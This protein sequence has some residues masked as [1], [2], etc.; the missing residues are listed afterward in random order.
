MAA[1][2]ALTTG[3]GLAG[4]GAASVAEAYPGP[5]P[6]YDWCAGQFWDPG[7]GNN[8][9]GGRCH[10]DFYGDGDP[11]DR[12][13]WNGPGDWRADGGRGWDRDHPG[14]PGGPGGRGWGGPGG[15][16]WGGPGDHGR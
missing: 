8:W 10:D 9:D 15:G 14:G 1:A 12:D 5:M 7:W 11:P 16:G 6:D 2:T 3:L 13:H 4:L